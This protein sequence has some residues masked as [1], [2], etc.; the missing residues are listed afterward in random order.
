MENSK[1]KMKNNFQ[2][3]I[4]IS[5]A[6]YLL[7]VALLYA[8]PSSLSTKLLYNI[9]PAITLL[10]S[11]ISIIFSVKSFKLRESKFGAVSLIIIG[12]VIILY[13]LL[14]FYFNAACGYQGDC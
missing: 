7:M 8:V 6:S 10:F 4:I 9:R 12:V 14:M 5:F 11:I 1:I 2:K 3:N 13:S